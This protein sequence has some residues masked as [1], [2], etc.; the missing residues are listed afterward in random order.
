VWPI[1]VYQNDAISQKS[2]EFIFR[3]LR[4]KMAFYRLAILLFGAALANN[5]S[6]LKSFERPESPVWHI[7]AFYWNTRPGASM[8]VNLI[9]VDI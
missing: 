8:R 4:D 1:T 6:A 5:S 2:P 7:G 9:F 3:H